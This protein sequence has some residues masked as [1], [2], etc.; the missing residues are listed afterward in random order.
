MAA[1]VDLAVITAAFLLFVLVFASCT[2][3]PPR[4]KAA[5]AAGG[6]VFALVAIFYEWLLLSYGVDTL[7]MRYAQVALCTFDD[8]NP[9]RSMRRRRVW[10]SLLASVPLGLGLVW[11]IFDDDALGWHDRMTRTYQRSYR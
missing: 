10:A 2:A 7:G 6:L 5:F 8:E 4:D 1:L 11:A 9:T 3:H